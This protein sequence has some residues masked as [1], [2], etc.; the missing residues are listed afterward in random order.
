M[1]SLT[2]FGLHRAF[3]YTAPGLYNHIPLPTVIFGI[4]T[5]YFISTGM[6][7]VTTIMCLFISKYFH[8]YLPK[9]FGKKYKLSKH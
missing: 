7:I 4:K 1:D 8:L 2:L 6:V 5:G 3:Y 9:F